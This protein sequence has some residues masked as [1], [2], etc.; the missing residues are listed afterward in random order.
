[1]SSPPLVNLTVK[2]SEFS[3]SRA[4]SRLTTAEALISFFQINAQ[5]GE[6]IQDIF[7]HRHRTGPMPWLFRYHDRQQGFKR[8]SHF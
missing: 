8:P 2:R 5:T 6:M 4:E 7:H 1:M 3:L